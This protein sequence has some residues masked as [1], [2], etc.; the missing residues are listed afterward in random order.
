MKSTTY[1]S[2]PVRKN[3][4]YIMRP[5]IIHTFNIKE[6]SNFIEL[7]FYL[8]NPELE[9]MLAM[10]PSVIFDDKMFIFNLLHTI[11]DEFKKAQTIPLCF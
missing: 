4:L 10:V 11:H 8:K 1:A 5:N 9:E 3:S 7:K 2:H 6:V